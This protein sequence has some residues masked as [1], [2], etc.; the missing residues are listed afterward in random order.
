VIRRCVE[1][2]EFRTI[3]GRGRDDLGALAG[4]RQRA[5]TRRA[6]RARLNVCSICDEAG[7]REPDPLP[8]TGTADWSGMR[9]SMRLRFKALI[10]TGA[11]GALI[12]TAAAPASAAPITC[13]GGQDAQRVNGDWVCV[14]S[15]DNPTGAGHHKGTGDKI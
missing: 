15:G 14:N 8:R 13:P 12:A 3:F 1:D 2:E 4:D 9:I 7:M 11:T 5:A 10:A 6:T